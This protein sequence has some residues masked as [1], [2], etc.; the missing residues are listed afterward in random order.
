MTCSRYVRLR[1]LGTSLVVGCVVV[2][3]ADVVVGNVVVVVVDVVD[4]VG[5]CV[6]VVVV[7]VVVVGVVSICPVAFLKQ[8][9]P[10]TSERS[11]LHEMYAASIVSFFRR[12]HFS[13]VRFPRGMERKF[14]SL[15]QFQAYPR[16]VLDPIH[17]PVQVAFGDWN[18][19]V[20]VSRMNASCISSIAGA[21]VPPSAVHRESASMKF[22]RLL[23]LGLV[24]SQ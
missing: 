6:C 14:G 4:V 12:R 15:F 3:L 17:T 24:V 19:P 7:G 8:M 20:K 16:M 10:R 22:Q 1:T 13:G 11:E 2:V 9:A 5:G 18:M 21:R 23:D